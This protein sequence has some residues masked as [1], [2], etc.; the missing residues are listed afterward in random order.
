MNILLIGRSR[1]RS[2]ACRDSGVP[3]CP[4]RGTLRGGGA[5]NTGVGMNPLGASARRAALGVALVLGLFLGTMTE[6]A[7]QTT[8]WAVIKCKFSDQ[9]QEP[10][11]DPAFI[12]GPYGMAGYWLGVS[13][14]RIRLDGSE[15]FPTNGG[16]Y[17]LPF[18]L[19]EGAAMTR[20]QRINACIAAAN[21]VDVSPFYS[22]IAIL[23]APVDS[24]S[25]GGRVLLDPLAWNSSFAAHEMGHVYIGVNHSFDDTQ[26][27]YCP[28]Y[29]PGEY[30]DGWDIMSAMTFG[31]T[32][33]IFAGVFG[34]SGPGLNAPNLDRLGWLPADRISTWDGSSQTVT[35][36]AL[37][38]PEAGGSLMLKVP[39]DAGNPAH[40]Y[41]VEYRRKTDWD[42]GIPRD[43][44]LI[45]E[46]R[47]DGISAGLSYLITGN[48][49]AERLPGSTYLDPGNN[50]AITVLAMDAL[51]SSAILN[52]GRK[53]VWVD[54]NH[55]GPLYLGSFDDPYATLADGVNSVGVRGTVRIKAGSRN[56]TATISKPM[57]L[58]AFGGPVTL[59]P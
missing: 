21:D 28:G 48:G 59:G 58:E 24:G 18:T 27:V 35:L 32:R 11:F 46:I 54:F 37:N 17:T 52:V 56:E 25:S 4:T 1:S 22:V 49:G 57:T 10:V 9:P 15:V 44:V 50:L 30:G 14:G 26:M 43:T 7:A 16:W 29:K 19:A 41:T 51:S 53:E 33:P 12:T 5:E 42:Q 2:P 45:H 38:H 31:G 34:A 40:Y 8:P 6:S 47:A 39:V 20:L 3:T 23:N 55:P 36:A 13:Y